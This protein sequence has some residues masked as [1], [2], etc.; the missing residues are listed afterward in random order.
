VTTRLWTRRVVSW[1]LATIALTATEGALGI[2]LSVRT[3]APPGAT[4]A[5]LAGAV[6]LI[7]ALWK[8]RP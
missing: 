8:G 1:Q 4:I 5:T 3:N 2:W 7:S 6:F